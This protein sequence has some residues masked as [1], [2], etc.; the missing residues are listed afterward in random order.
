MSPGNQSSTNLALAVEGGVRFYA[1]KNVSFDISLKYEG[2]PS[3]N[4]NIPALTPLQTAGGAIVSQNPSH[5]TQNP[6]FNLFSAQV[7]VAYHF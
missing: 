3:R 6:A 5:F 4:S 7:G 1:L 2:M